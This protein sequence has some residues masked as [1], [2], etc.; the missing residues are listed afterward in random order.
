MAQKKFNIVF[1]Y[2]ES[3]LGHYIFIL[4]KGNSNFPKLILDVGFCMN[5]FFYFLFYML[6][7]GTFY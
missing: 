6:L 4:S 2:H 7:I 3:N 1:V 5:L